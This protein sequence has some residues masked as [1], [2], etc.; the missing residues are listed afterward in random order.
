MDPHQETAYQAL[1]LHGRHLSKPTVLASHHSLRH[2]Q[3][4]YQVQLLLKL[5]S[6]VPLLDCNIIWLFDLSYS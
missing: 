6:G 4:A 1:H 5:V 3:Q 2:H